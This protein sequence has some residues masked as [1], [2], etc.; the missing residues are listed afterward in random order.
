MDAVKGDAPRP[1]Q[2]QDRH[3]LR[4]LRGPEEE[5]GTGA[6]DDGG[7]AV[8]VFQRGGQ[9]HVAAELDAQ[10]VDAAVDHG[11]DLIGFQQFRRGRRL[12]IIA[13]DAEGIGLIVVGEDAVAQDVRLIALVYP[14]AVDHQLIDRGMDEKVLHQLVLVPGFDIDGAV[15]HLGIGRDR[16][17]AAREGDAALEAVEA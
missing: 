4:A 10:L 17:A 8:V 16:P 15:C 14:C 7:I 9:G 5:A 1:R 13:G 12:A 3:G 6:V 2:G 11:A